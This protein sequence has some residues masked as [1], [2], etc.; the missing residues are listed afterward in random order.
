MYLYEILDIML[1]VKKP[2]LSLTLFG[3]RR[4]LRQPRAQST[5]LIDGR[6]SRAPIVSV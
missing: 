5:P 1:R 4:L 6:T 3:C 2:K